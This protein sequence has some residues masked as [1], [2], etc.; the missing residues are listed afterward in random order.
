M[1]MTDDAD[2]A[3]DDDDDDGDGDDDQ[4]MASGCNMERYHQQLPGA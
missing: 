1:V 2:D 3:A 4:T